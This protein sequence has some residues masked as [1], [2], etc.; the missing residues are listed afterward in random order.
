MAAAQPLAVGREQRAAVG[1]DGQRGGIPA[2]GNETGDPRLVGL[3]NVDRHHVVVVGVGH[4]EHLAVAGD[5][6]GVGRAALQ[7]RGIE[8]CRKNL[9]GTFRRTPFATGPRLDLFQCSRADHVD[10]VVAGAGHEQSAVG[11]EGHVVGPDAHVLVA[12]PL[13]RFRVDDGHAAAAPIRDVEVPAVAAEN[14]GMG[15]LADGNRCLE[16]QVIGSEDPDFVVGLVGHVKSACLRVNGDAGQEDVSRLGLRPRRLARCQLAVLICE[17]VDPAG[18]AARHEEALAVAAEG[19]PV[20]DPRQ[21]EELPDLLR[22]QVDHRQARI[23]VARTR[24]QQ[25]LAIGRDN[26]FQRKIAGHSPRRLLKLGVR[27]DRLQVIQRDH[28]P[29]RRDGPTVEQLRAGLCGCRD[30]AGQRSGDQ[31]Q[32][33]RTKTGSRE[34]ERHSVPLLFAS[35]AEPTID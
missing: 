3:G 29:G 7:R 23:V 25:Q 20:P 19:Q 17:N 6:H 22:G 34:L 27:D 13:A 33:E 15:V 26:H 32:K 11:R 30:G 10:G 21:G 24:G 18:A 16:L 2:D 8:R 5:G 12:D 4:V 31:G 35:A 14:A 28:R 1:R 9:P